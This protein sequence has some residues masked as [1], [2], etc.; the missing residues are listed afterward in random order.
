MDAAV[1]RRSVCGGENNV[2]GR[3]V[4]GTT[5]RMTA[6]GRRGEELSALWG[7]EGC[8]SGEKGRRWSV[9]QWGRMAE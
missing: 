2:V 7:E 5:A 8:C 9:L 6:R 3:M 4:C 1:G